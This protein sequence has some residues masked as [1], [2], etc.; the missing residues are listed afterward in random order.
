MFRILVWCILLCGLTFTLLKDIYFVFVFVFSLMSKCYIDIYRPMSWSNQ[1]DNNFTKMKD[2]IG[3][4]VFLKWIVNHITGTFDGVCDTPCA[5]THTH[6]HTTPRRIPFSPT[7]MT[8][9][10]YVVKLRRFACA[11]GNTHGHPTISNPCVHAPWPRAAPQRSLCVYV[12]N[13]VSNVMTFGHDHHF[14]CR[15]PIARHV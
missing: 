3:K 1:F 14:V 5:D 8:A 15:L 9:H 7:H 13:V 4:L 11:V 2:L 6:T 10:W 12:H